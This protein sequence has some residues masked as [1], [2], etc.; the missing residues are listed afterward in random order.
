MKTN[1]Q[2]NVKKVKVTMVHG[3][4]SC[5]K[6]QK[7]IAKA[8]GFSRP[9]DTRELPDLPSTRGAVKKLEHLLKIEEVK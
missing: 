6:R 3:L 5:T 7:A 2:D 4:D 8:L 1:K 9:N